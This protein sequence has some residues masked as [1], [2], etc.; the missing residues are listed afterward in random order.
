[1]VDGGWWVVDGRWWVVDGGWWLGGGGDRTSTL[2]QRALP[3]PPPPPTPH[4]PRN[5]SAPLAVVIAPC[6][7]DPVATLRLWRREEERD[8]LELEDLHA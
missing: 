4:P 6:F 8:T 7:R 5:P 3:P 2:A 1:M